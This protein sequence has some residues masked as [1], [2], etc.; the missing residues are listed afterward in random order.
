M[1]K[2]KHQL[3]KPDGRDPCSQMVLAA[4][5]ALNKLLSQE[6]GVEKL[7]RRKKWID[8]A[9]PIVTAAHSKLRANG[10]RGKVWPTLVE[11]GELVKRFEEIT[12]A[13]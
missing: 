9:R 7:K 3:A 11:A 2:N 4:I 8:F 13:D 1:L 5:R 6:Q 12:K 10:K